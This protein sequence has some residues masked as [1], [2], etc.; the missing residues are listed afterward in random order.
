MD[1]KYSNNI[2]GVIL[3]GGKSSRLGTNKALLK[4][5]N[6]TLIE[7]TF[8]LLKSIF[9]EVLISTNNPEEYDFIDARKVKDV[10]PTMGPL[11]GIH[12]ALNSSNSKK[13]FILSCD[14][15]FIIQPLIKH[16]LNV[17]T[18]EPIVI[19]KVGQKT[20]YLCG[21]YNKSLL[22]LLESILLAAA[23]ALDKKE[24]VK[25]SALSVWNFAERVGGEFV[26][27]EHERF[28]FNDLFFNINTQE[29]Y[30]YA[31]ERL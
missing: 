12:S 30:E 4:I 22:P 23:N 29:D 9:N 18:E 31:L 28:Y 27:I 11:S 15:P 3:A 8:Y 10:Y 20:E 14:M 17:R 25:N 5:D 2:T 26:D 7:R 13:I 24:E 16:L 19:P 21:I 6:E 1:E